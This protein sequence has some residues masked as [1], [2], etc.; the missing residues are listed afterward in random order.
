MK[1]LSKVI[2][3]FIGLEKGFLQCSHIDLSEWSMVIKNKN[4]K[5]SR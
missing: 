2:Y 4:K 1:S 5:T 3:L